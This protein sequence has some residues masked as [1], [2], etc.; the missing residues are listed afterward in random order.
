M[1]N[2]CDIATVWVFNGARSNFPSAVFSKRGLAE[3]WIA[4]HLLTGT[5]TRYP[6]DVS[7]YDWAISRGF[8]EVSKS[9]HR[10]G[11]FIQKFS[12]AS[13]EHYHY[14]EGIRQGGEDETAQG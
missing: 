4:K 7:S 8:F 10:E 5:L 11:S 12:S 2:M 9:E 14:E 6:L 1:A 13:Q 3:Q